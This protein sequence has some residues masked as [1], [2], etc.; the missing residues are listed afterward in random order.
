MI[1]KVNKNSAQD[2]QKRFHDD[3]FVT[4]P[5]FVDAESVTALREAYDDLLTGKVPIGAKDDRWLGSVTRQIEHP[6]E[7]HPLFADNAALRAG[8]EI[9]HLIA[10]ADVTVKH[11]YD[12]LLFKPPQHE[13]ETP[14]HQD[15]SY[16][17]EP[18]APA[19]YHLPNDSVLQ[20]W[21]ALDDTDESNGCMQ[22]IA[23]AHNEPLLPHHVAS[24]D[25]QQPS[26]L[27]AIENVE[28]HLN[29]Q[30][31]RVCPLSAGGAT[32]HGYLTPHY[33]GPNL[34]QD[35]PRRA[36]IFTFTVTPNQLP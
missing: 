29:L 18:F 23:G 1:S 24:G 11:I 25:P 3:G 2:V 34:T 16:L 30:T 26:R 20:F 4:L 12:Q 36:Y 17:K 14:W 6:S 27:L 21:L 19:G 8:T 15:L 31:A 33:T 10:G 32:V 35:K 5:G 13:F 22:F 28:Q 9:A 7:Y